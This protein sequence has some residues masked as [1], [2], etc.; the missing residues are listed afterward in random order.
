ML[1]CGMF[2]LEL[3]IG[4]LLIRS[5]SF[6]IDRNFYKHCGIKIQNQIRITL[7]TI[8]NIILTNLNLIFFKNIVC[9]QHLCVRA[10]LNISLVVRAFSLFLLASLPSNSK[11][12]LYSR[13]TKL[14]NFSLTILTFCPNF[15]TFFFQ[16]W[17]RFSRCLLKFYLFSHAKE[18]FENTSAIRKEARDTTFSHS[19]VEFFQVQSRHQLYS[20]SFFRGGKYFSM[21]S[22]TSSL[23]LSNPPPIAVSRIASFLSCRIVSFG[24][25][26]L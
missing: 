18:Q 10:F 6:K 13:I 12:L 3:K 1:E 9:E 4:D 7:E 19:F 16:K 21:P 14:N 15:N 8:L 5:L 23:R 22:P 11:E 20:L 25:C 2:T 17:R 26:N 24:V